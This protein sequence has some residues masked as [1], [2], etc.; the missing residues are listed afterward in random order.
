MPGI[1]KCAGQY[2]ETLDANNMT[3]NTMIAA[4]A[5]DVNSDDWQRRMRELQGGFILA[6][7]V[8][9]VLGVTGLVGV[10]LHYIGPLTIAPVITMIAL[11][12]VNVT[13][14]YCQHN[15][16]IAF[17]YVSKSFLFSSFEF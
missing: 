11:S 4:A 6:S 14:G 5:S 2:N 3:N 12:L 8:E 1:A 15:W 7:L 9:T 13:S 16:F 10:L 17:L